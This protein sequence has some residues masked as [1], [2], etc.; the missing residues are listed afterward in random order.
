M[1][2]LFVIMISVTMP[3]VRSYIVKMFCPFPFDSFSMYKEETAE[4]LR[5]N[6]LPG[7]EKTEYT[8]KH[9]CVSLSMPELM[10]E[11]VKSYF[12]HG[13]FF[14]EG[15][16]NANTQTKFKHGIVFVK[17]KASINTNIKRVHYITCVRLPKNFLKKRNVIKT[18]MQD[19]MY[20]ATLSR[21]RSRSR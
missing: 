8:K 5:T 1:M 20:K 18:E 17:G 6:F 14:I 21:V 3:F 15:K 4:R 12:R 19:G 9:I 11:D 10:I 13:A 7:L 2:S 16:T